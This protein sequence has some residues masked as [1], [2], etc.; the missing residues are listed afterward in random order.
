VAVW[1]GTQYKKQNDENKIGKQEKLKLDID[2]KFS[3]ADLR[4]TN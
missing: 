4:F 2:H 3:S 1:F